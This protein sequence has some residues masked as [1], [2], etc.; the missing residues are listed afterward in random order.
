M[1]GLLFPYSDDGAPGVTLL[2]TSSGRLE[3]M[4][5]GLGQTILVHGVPLNSMNLSLRGDQVVA[6]LAAPFW[7]ADEMR[8]ADT[9]VQTDL[10]SG[11]IALAGKNWWL[12]E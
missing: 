3:N 1:P 9:G 10:P 12:S 2:V 4:S 7:F 6:A 8:P 11:S 5:A